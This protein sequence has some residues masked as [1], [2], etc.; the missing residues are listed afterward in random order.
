M[1]IATV[2]MQVL[3]AFVLTASTL[4][5]IL[6]AVPAARDPVAGPVLGGGLLVVIFAVVWLVWP[7]RRR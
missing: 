7:R 5:V 1:R 6:V 3:I 2:L 4:P